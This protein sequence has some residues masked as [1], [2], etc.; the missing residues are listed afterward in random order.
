MLPSVVPILFLPID[1]DRVRLVKCEKTANMK[2][3]THFGDF[4]SRKTKLVYHYVN[5]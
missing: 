4:F 2:S 1:L 5:H 3:V